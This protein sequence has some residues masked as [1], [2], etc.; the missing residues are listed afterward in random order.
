MSYVVVE[1]LHDLRLAEF[2]RMK[3]EVEGIPAL[4]NSMGLAQLFGELLFGGIRVE[5]PEEYAARAAVLLAEVKSDLAA[6]R[7]PDGHAHA[8]PA[9][10]EAPRREVG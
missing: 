4:M 5:V 9:R 2:A 6:T 8:P 7:I 10:S 1:T 3:F